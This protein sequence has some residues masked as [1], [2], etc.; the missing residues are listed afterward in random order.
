M[1]IQLLVSVESE[2]E[3]AGVL[4]K[5][6]GET[7]VEEVAAK[8]TRKKKAKKKTTRKK[9]AK[10]APEPEAEE[11]LDDLDF[12][13]DEKTT[14]E[15]DVRAALKKYVKAKGAGDLKKGRLAAKKLLKKY[16]A[17]SV[18]TLGA[19]DFDDIIADCE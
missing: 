2:K 1:N 11:D 7:D 16:G 9:A 10:K 19:E 6:N 4:A 18:D 8:T 17:T 14:T 5:L 3:L 12:E 15:D 13:D